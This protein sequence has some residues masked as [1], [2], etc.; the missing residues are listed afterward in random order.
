MRG[1]KAFHRRD[2]YPF[3]G[4]AIINSKAFRDFDVFLP[5]GGSFGG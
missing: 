5:T 3:V 2:L 4:E 1:G